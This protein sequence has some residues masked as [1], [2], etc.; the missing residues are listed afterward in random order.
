MTFNR[1]MTILLVA[2]FV[3]SLTAKVVSATHSSVKV[4]SITVVSR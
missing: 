3:A 4:A 2:V 1:T